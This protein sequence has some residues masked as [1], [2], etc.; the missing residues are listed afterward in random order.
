MLSKPEVSMSFKFSRAPQK[1]NLQARKDQGS[2]KV[3]ARA[4]SEGSATSGFAAW[5][6]ERLRLS[7][8]LV[9]LLP[10]P[11]RLEG[12]AF[13]PEGRG[14][15]HACLAGKPE[16]FRRAGG[17]AARSNSAASR[18]V[19]PKWCICHPE[20]FEGALRKDYVTLFNP[21]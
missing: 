11:L 12:S 20:D 8:A 3:K 4:N 7:V 15:K 1:C 17:R 14:K 21:V 16:A 18:P 10:P 9:P 6:A 19:T 5:C 13:Q 2:A